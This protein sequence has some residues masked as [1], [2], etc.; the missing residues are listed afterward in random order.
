M[1][2]FLCFHFLPHF[3]YFELLI[4]RKLLNIY[5]NL[6]YGGSIF[7]KIKSSSNFRFLNTFKNHF[8]ISFIKPNRILIPFFMQNDDNKTHLGSEMQIFNYTLFN[9]SLTRF[10]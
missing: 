1:N 4:N 2:R 10:K 6:L 5:L 8:E 3:Y 9:R 7:Y